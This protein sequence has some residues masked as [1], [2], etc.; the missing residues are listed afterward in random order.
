MFYQRL[1]SE[2]QVEDCE[3]LDMAQDIPMLT[4]QKKTSLEGEI[5]LAEASLALK[6]MKNYKSPGSDG[7]TAE[8]FK[9]FWLQLGSFVV[10][11]LNGGF[12]KGELSTTQKEGVIICIPKGDKSKD[13][14][15][16]WR[17]ISLLNVVYKIGSA[18]IAKRLKSVLPSL[19]NEDQTGFMANRYIGDNIRLIYDLISYLYR[20]NKPGLLLC[21]DFEKAFDSVDWKFMF[22]VLRAFGFGPDIF[23]WIS[24][25]YKD[26][27]SSVTING[28]FVWNRKQDRISRKIAVRSIAKG[29]LG[30]PNIKT[31]INALKLIWIRKLKTSEHKWKSMIKSTYPKVVWF[32]QLRS[33][34]HFQEHEVNKFWS[35]VFMAYKE[36]GKQ[37]HVENSEELVAELI[38]CNQNI[39]VG[40]RI[41]LY[42]NWIDKGVCHMKNMLNDN[43]TLM[44]FKSFKEKFGI[45]TDYITYIGCEQAIKSYIRKTEITVEGKNSAD[46][47]KTLKTIYNQRKGSRLYY[48]VLTQNITRP[49]CCDKWEAKLNK[50]INWCI[51]F[52]KM[53]Q[54]QEIKLKWF[55]I[56][57]V[58]RIIATNVVLMH[59]GTENDITCSF[60][61]Q[62]RDAIN[63][64]FWFMYT[65]EVILGTI[66]DRT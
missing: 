63:H 60:C 3:I 33:S 23:Q 61:R 44:S 1:Y 12:R 30:I 11:S 41:I 29:G 5:T 42:K 10:R 17:P 48:E 19:I 35:H 49:N 59:M 38:F 66:P 65:R 26:I 27:K 14:I 46:L 56:R 7:F 62:D 22:K 47:I 50:D 24:T 2:R 57:L 18:C 16:N 21:L 36:F 15:K 43:G 34:L 9:F 52:K 6:N 53:Q 64:I 4:L 25:F 54:I 8:F 51:T 39:L 40:N 58:H 28:Q 55:Q 37:I 13:L 31:Y 20:E 45:K 32:E